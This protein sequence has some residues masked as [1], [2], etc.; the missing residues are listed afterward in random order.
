MWQVKRLV[1]W[2]NRRLH[3]S[4]QQDGSMGK[5]ACWQRWVQF[6]GYTWWR[7]STSTS[8]PLDCM[9][10]WHAHKVRHIENWNEKRVLSVESET[11][12]LE[13]SW[14]MVFLSLC[15]SPP[16]DSSMSLLSQQPFLSLVLTCLKGQDEQREG[17]LASLHSQVHQVRVS[18]VLEVTSGWGR[19]HLRGHCMLGLFIIFW[20]K[21]FNDLE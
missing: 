16:R 14:P 8:F 4:V 11:R 2:P 17:L 9:Y 6:P 13:G 1:A 18:G 21:T 5:T 7:E 19:V 20:L 15:P 12:E 10:K 3:L